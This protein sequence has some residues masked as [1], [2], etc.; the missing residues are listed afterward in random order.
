MSNFSINL[1]TA[2]VKFDFT[3]RPARKTIPCRNWEE[4]GSCNYGKN[5]LYK[6]E[7]EEGDING[8]AVNDTT[9]SQFQE[10][11]KFN[12]YCK[13]RDTCRFAHPEKKIDY[14]KTKMCPNL[15]T[16]GK[17]A[18]VKQCK[19]AHLEE[20][21]R[22][23]K[24]TYIGQN[25]L[26]EAR[27]SRALKEVGTVQ[28]EDIPKPLREV[29]IAPSPKINSNEKSC[30]EESEKT[31]DE[32][33]KE[34]FKGWNIIL[35][36]VSE[37]PRTI[38]ERPRNV[39]PVRNVEKVEEEKT[40]EEK[41]EKD[42]G[43]DTL[44]TKNEKRDKVSPT[45]EEKLNF[46]KRVLPDAK[47]EET[48]IDFF[49]NM[50]REWGGISDPVELTTDELVNYIQKV[51]HSTF[52]MMKAITDGSSIDVVKSLYHIAMDPNHEDNGFIF[53]EFDKNEP[54]KMGLIAAG[55]SGRIKVAQW[56]LEYTPYN[57]EDIYDAICEAE[58]RSHREFVKFMRSKYAYDREAPM[59]G[60]EEIQ[61]TKDDDTP[62][63]IFEVVEAVRDKSGDKSHSNSC[64]IS[65]N[66]SE[67]SEDEYN[68]EK[69]IKKITT[70]KDNIE[71][72][73][74]KLIEDNVYE[75]I[76]KLLKKIDSMIKN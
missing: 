13:Y 45:N 10:E 68:R 35:D 28:R 72:D 20:E 15:A 58:C 52:N 32:K 34:E 17:C 60:E 5:C 36:G 74:G 27:Q 47:I 14:T 12:P 42:E 18:N 41:N 33:P 46:I 61:D 26:G 63:V 25:P 67:I 44:S 22:Q 49:Y 57:F 71:K 69:L 31:A 30:S 66:W 76:K 70:L 3:S 38:G 8:V 51:R 7:G 56:F 48:S 53:E 1:K 21:L 24:V 9:P 40:N 59:G 16:F 50:V 37:S 75:E 65:S 62:E 11:C 64:D 2:E 19:F 23:P 6:H 4:T 73:E 55:I 39:S 29:G 54:T 43:K